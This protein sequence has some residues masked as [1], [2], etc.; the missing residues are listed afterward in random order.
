M[1]PS[2]ACTPPAWLDRQAY[3]FRSRWT[4]SAGSRLHYVDEGSG[5]ALLFVHGTPTWSFEFRHV[6][7]ALAPRYRCIA[8]DHLG[9]GLSDRPPGA[10]YSPEAHAARLQ[11]FVEGLGLT[12]FTLVVHDYGGPIGLPLALSPTSQVE[13]LVLMN[14][15]MWPFDD[16]VEMMRR[17]KL[18]GGSLGRFLYRYANASLRLLMPSA[19][20]DRKKLTS[21]IHRQYLDVFRD[22]GARVDVLHALARALLESRDY[23]ADLQSRAHRLRDIPALIIWGMKDIAF[24]PN[25]LARWQSVLPAATVCRLSSAGHWPHEEEPAAVINAITE[26]LERRKATNVDAGCQASV[27]ARG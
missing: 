23:Y 12:R 5:D 1:T 26:F 25:Q 16:D 11:S 2:A 3:P 4:A 18:A 27:A 21:A 20:G 9:F 17:A 15:W 22:R 8:A 24:Q 13:R 10:N 14:T 19:Y 6:I 7:A